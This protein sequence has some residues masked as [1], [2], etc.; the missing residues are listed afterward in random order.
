MTRL[1]DFEKDA[2]PGPEIPQSFG[3]GLAGF[4]GLATHETDKSESPKDSIVNP[5][6]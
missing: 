4:A 5:K 3:P 2:S 1:G 6:P